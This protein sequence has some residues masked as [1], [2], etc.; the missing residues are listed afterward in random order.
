MLKISNL[1]KTHNATITK[2]GL[3]IKF[4]VKVQV[5]ITHDGTFLDNHYPSIKADVWILTQIL[6][7]YKDNLNVRVPLKDYND[8]DKIFSIKQTFS[9][10][11]PGKF[12]I[13]T[14]DIKVKMNYDLNEEMN[15][16]TPDSELSINQIKEKQIR[17]MIKRK[18][19]Q[20]E[21]IR[22]KRA[23]IEK[24]LKT[25]TIV[26][27]SSEIKVINWSKIIK[28]RLTFGHNTRI[29]DNI[30]RFKLIQKSVNKH[31]LI[32]RLLFIIKMINIQ[33]I[34]RQKR[35][36][37]ALM[38]SEITRYKKL[39]FDYDMKHE[40]MVKTFIWTG[41]EN[42][43]N[44]N[45]Q[46]IKAEKNGDIKRGDSITVETN[47]NKNSY[48][49]NGHKTQLTKSRKYKIGPRRKQR[50]QQAQSIGSQD[51]SILQAASEYTKVCAKARSPLRLIRTRFFEKILRGATN[52][53]QK[54]M[55]SSNDIFD[56]WGACWTRISNIISV[57]DV[58]YKL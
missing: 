5:E 34:I 4:P 21:E 20:K 9:K 39:K 46:L 22:V 19:E 2:D 47:N 30:S 1:D 50:I 45:S 12:K 26:R 35:E 25:R 43:K 10:S 29:L 53:M 18:E 3:E 31:I 55:K 41:H 27:I 57:R 49:I 7:S 36:K 14:K 28:R 40:E 24:D 56:I 11:F 16:E 44:C 58:L 13:D 8:G 48:M 17:H 42:H 52:L 37:N 54:V 38:L 51:I 15:I 6:L 33:R 32:I 23:Q